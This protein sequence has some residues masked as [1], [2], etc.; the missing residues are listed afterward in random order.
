MKKQR[1]TRLLLVCAMGVLLV[2]CANPVPL[3][4]TPTPTP[5]PAA[6]TASVPAYWPTE[7]WRKSI[8]E[9][10]GVDSELL[11]RLIDQ[12]M[13]RD[14]QVHSLLVAR[15]GYIVAEATFFPF[16]QGIKH[17]LWSA[18][19]SVVSAV[20]GVA[21]QQ[22][23]IGGVDDNV[24]DYFGGRTIAN[25]DTRKRVMTLEHLLTMTSGV[26]WTEHPYNSPDT[27]LR[28]MEQTQDWV[29]YVLDLPMAKE[30]GTTY[31]YSSGESHLL[32]A[33]V[34]GA[35]GMSTLSYAQTHL[36]GPLGISGVEW[37]SDPTGVAVG[38]YGLWMT[39]RD[40]ARLGYL[41]L[42]D[43]VWDGQQILPP[44]WVGASTTSHTQG[45]GYQWWTWS[46]GAYAA[47]GSGGQLIEV[48]PDKQTVI[49]LTGGLPQS[50][51]L[52]LPGELVAAYILP[53][54]Q[55]SGPLPENPEGAALLRARIREAREGPEPQ[56]VPLLP[57]TAGR[58]AGKTYLFEGG[59]A[60]YRMSIAF[61]DDEAML[62]WLV[63]NQRREY[64]IGLD[65]VYRIS[66]IEGL[67]TI[68]AK[69]R[70]RDEQTFV[71]QLQTLGQATE[72]EWRLTFTEDV[73]YLV[74]TARGAVEYVQTLTGKLSD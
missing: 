60:S 71:A 24:L 2:G 74:I 3:S 70:W 35:T 42:R 17:Q 26:E 52:R 13:K 19:K 15:N 49:V 56:P 33:V 40:M 12:V 20:V 8:P 65:G 44:G 64:R 30:P 45:Y 11:A 29:Q 58:V 67:F 63:G 68:A 27:S 66:D 7:R 50:E 14:H 32:S 53:A 37:W 61:G 59:A 43:G 22:G 39:P 36:F 51:S 21:V 16:Q 55:S 6:A 25:L 1:F 18:T 23:H 72:E 69:G 46:S 47:S 54:I 4:P 41:Y 31:N 9:E 73:V 38:G 10:Q 57:E 48:I 34:Q 62:V 5:D 28:K